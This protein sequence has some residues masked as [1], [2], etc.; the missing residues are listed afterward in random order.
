MSDQ[1]KYT[2]KLHGTKVL[3]IG[4][5]SGIG[6]AVAEASIEHGAKVI[7]SSSNEGRV[8]DAVKKLQS[9]YPSRK[10]DISGVACNLKSEEVEGNIVKLLERSGVVDHIVF[11][12]GDGLATIPMEEYTL[13]MIREAG[14]YL[15][16]QFYWEYLASLSGVLTYFPCGRN[17][18]IL[19]T[20]P[21]SETR[22][23]VL[24]QRS[25]ILNHTDN[26]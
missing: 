22:F 23:E 11:T 13:D 6:F 1:Q 18:S 17:G 3:I 20:N 26:R 7:I 14:V 15:F 10:A 25:S 12:A 2:A 5:S 8:Q 4:G 24:K 9:S 16:F 19:C 21:F